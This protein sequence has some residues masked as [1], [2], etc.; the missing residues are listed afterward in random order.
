M[1]LRFRCLKLG[2]I[3]I[4]QKWE[5]PSVPT[6]S[7]KNMC[8]TSLVSW[9]FQTVTLGHA[10][11]W[12]LLD[13]AC[14]GPR[15]EYC[16]ILMN[17]ETSWHFWRKFDPYRDLLNANGSSFCFVRIIQQDI[18]WCVYF[19]VYILEIS[20]LSEIKS[21]Y[22]ISKFII[23]SHWSNFYFILLLP[24]WP[25]S[26]ILC[27]PYVSLRLSNTFSSHNAPVQCQK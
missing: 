17:R 20:A 8:V 25:V 13:R 2:L 6:L 23:L 5:I 3:I 21:P 24:A 16:Q 10:T 7:F 9:G 14:S 1:P 22:Y 12:S 15:P 11:S 18:F 27:I 26:F 4:K 19:G